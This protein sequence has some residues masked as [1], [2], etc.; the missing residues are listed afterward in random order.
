MTDFL[1]SQITANVFTLRKEPYQTD[2]DI[3]G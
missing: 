2:D 1:T 3:I